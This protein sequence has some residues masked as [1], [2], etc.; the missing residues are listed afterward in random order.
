MP[1]LPADVKARLTVRVPRG[2]QAF[3]EI[4]RE[5][6]TFTLGDVEQRCNVHRDTIGEYVRRLAKAKIVA[7][8]DKRGT[9]IVY[10]LLVDQADAPSVRRDGTLT[11]PQGIGQE[12]MWRSMKMLK[13]FDAPELAAAASLDDVTVTT[14]TAADY[15]KNLY[16][17][18]YLSVVTPAKGG[19]T[20]YP[21]R[22]RLRPNMIT[23][24]LAPQIQRTQWVWDPNRK[25]VMGPEAQP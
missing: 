21:A 18:G 23:G 20:G 8:T 15:I 4:M 14:A 10:R 24:P 16:H 13:T 25:C 5:L 7:A 3:W 2:Q 17:A 6:R 11:I 9:E 22:Y 19:G 12:R 1:C